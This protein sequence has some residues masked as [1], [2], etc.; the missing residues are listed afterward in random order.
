MNVQIQNNE[1]LAFITHKGKKIFYSDYSGLG[2]EEMLD[3]LKT[4]YE[5]RK[6][7][8]EEIKYILINTSDANITRP[9]L[10]QIKENMTIDLPN[11]IKASI[12]GITGVKKALLATANRFG[13]VSIKPFNTA[14]D[15]KE[16]LIS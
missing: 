11:L 3:L 15:A 12:I 14:E 2:G 4:E 8:G 16:W 10:A 9:C 6:S 1:K 5:F 13:A 7:H